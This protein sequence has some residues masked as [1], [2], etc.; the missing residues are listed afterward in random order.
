MNILF[1]L[2]PKSEVIYLYADYTLRQAL[3]KMEQYRYTAV[4]VIDRNGKYLGTLTEGDLLWF[5]KSQEVDSLKAMENYRI[6][7]VKRHRDNEAVSIECN[8]ED[9]VQASLNQNFVPVVD[10]K[11]VFIGI[12][13]RKSIIEYF[14]G[15][16][17]KNLI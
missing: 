11:D 1:H 6:D 17:K 15:E 13:T 8:M 10:D 2:H 14:F 12:V 4:P 9:L 3:E 7:S 16:Y 5:I